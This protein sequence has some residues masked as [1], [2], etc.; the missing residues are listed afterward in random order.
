MTAIET[1]YLGPTARRGSRIVAVALGTRQRIMLPLMP[2]WDMAMAHLT[3]AQSLA[4]QYEWQGRWVH[5]DSHHGR[6]IW[7]CAVAG[8]TPPIHT[9]SFY[10]AEVNTR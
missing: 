4:Y 10:V 5:G 2:E 7:V 8:L 1:Y 3:A 6:S 9:R